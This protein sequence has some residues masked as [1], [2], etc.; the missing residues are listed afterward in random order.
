M[1][2]LL[3]FL[4][5][6]VVP[7]ADVVVILCFL[8]LAVEGLDL[9]VVPLPMMVSSFSLLLY[10]AVVFSHKFGGIGIIVFVVSLMEEGSGCPQGL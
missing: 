3:P 8:V 6:R 7:F 4:L 2:V 10:P 9:V 1:I 5:L